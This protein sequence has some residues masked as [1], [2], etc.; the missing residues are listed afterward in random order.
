MQVA[1]VL[2]GAPIGEGGKVQESQI[3]AYSFISR[4]VDDFLLHFAGENDIPV[5]RFSFDHTGFHLPYRRV[6]FLAF[7]E[8]DFDRANGGETHPVILGQRKAR[9]WKREGV[10]APIPLEA[11]IARRL[12][13]FDTTKEG[14]KSFL[15]PPQDILQH[16][17]VDSTILRPHFFDLR[18]L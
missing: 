7:G 6:R 4:M 14:I 10:I 2:N 5:L 12:S 9:L 13:L 16:L 17:G 18:Q 8:L 11:W 1:G 15:Y 3:D